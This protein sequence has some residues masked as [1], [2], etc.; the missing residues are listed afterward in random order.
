LSK[1]AR[2][3]A[4]RLGWATTGAMSTEKIEEELAH[5]ARAIEDLHEMV[6]DQGARMD[7]L[8]RRVAML[9]ERA[10][11]AEAQNTGGVVIGDERPPHY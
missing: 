4:R 6:V 8:E 11:V 2:G 10:A 9:L 7:V 1:V 5:L 3:L